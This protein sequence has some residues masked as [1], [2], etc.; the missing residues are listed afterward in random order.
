MREE[1]CQMLPADKKMKKTK[2][3]LSSGDKKYL[4]YE[5]LSNFLKIT[6]HNEMTYF[7]FDSLRHVVCLKIT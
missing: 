1:S 2:K 6:L 3:N 5:K 4:I 7:M